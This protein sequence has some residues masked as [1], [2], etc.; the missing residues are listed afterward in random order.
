ME[1]RESGLRRQVRQ[2]SVTARVEQGAAL[3]KKAACSASET[4]PSSQIQVPA[5]WPA[6]SRVASSTHRH[7]SSSSWTWRATAKSE[8]VKESGMEGERSAGELRAASP[9]PWRGRRGEEAP[10]MRQV[11][12]L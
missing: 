4:L 6:A 5:R 10:K 8:T 1:P 12:S 7:V 11:W 3:T 2:C 9:T